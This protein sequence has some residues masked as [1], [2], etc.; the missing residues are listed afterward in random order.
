M[1]NSNLIKL[2]V[3][4]LFYID[5]PDGII[6]MYFSWDHVFFFFFKGPK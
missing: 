2:L 5:I 4:N 6:D 3:C 1:L